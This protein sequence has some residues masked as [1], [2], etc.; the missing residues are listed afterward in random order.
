MASRFGRLDRFLAKQLNQP[1][2]QIRRILA[3]GQVSVDH[4]ECRNPQC[5]V[6]PFTHVQIEETV[7]QAQAP[8]YIMLHKPKGVVSATKD[9]EHETVM[10]LI[11]HADK[12][13][14]HI[15][16]RLDLNSTGLVLLTNDGRW[17]RSHAQPETKVEKGYRVTVEHPISEDCI[18]Q[19]A[20]GI[21]F[22]FE[23][24]TTAPVR[25]TL[26]SSR[27]AELRLTEGKYHQIKRMF[28]RF[29]NPVL[30]LHRFC[31]GDLE[32]PDTLLPGEWRVLTPQEAALLGEVAVPSI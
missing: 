20:A 27:C 30:S 31:I 16:G 13:S 32:L 7:L 5:I 24:I 6:G 21:Y 2:K 29:R 14:L 23:D 22:G 10:D 8:L 28:G 26:L 4:V 3:S 12:A 18:Q 25:L 15:T 19:F 9:D 17:S 1:L 11:D